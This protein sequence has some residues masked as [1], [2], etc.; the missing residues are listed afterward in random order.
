MLYFSIILGSLIIC[1]GL[2]QIANAIS[3]NKK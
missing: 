1:T 2:Y 3:K